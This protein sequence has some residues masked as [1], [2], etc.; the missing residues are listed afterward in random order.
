M[1]PLTHTGVHCTHGFN[2][3]GFVICSYLVEDCDMSIELA[4]S[5]F[6]AARPPGIYKCPTTPR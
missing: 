5:V 6:A 1:S 3:T 2:R 4:I